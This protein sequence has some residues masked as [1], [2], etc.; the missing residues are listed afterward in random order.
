MKHFYEQESSQ[1][2]VLATLFPEKELSVST[3]S[4]GTRAILEAE[5]MCLCLP[6]LDPPPPPGGGAGGGGG[7]PVRAV[8]TG[9]VDWVGG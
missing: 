4:V 1:L 8:G 9:W 5:E 3:D 7:G 6:G 2:W